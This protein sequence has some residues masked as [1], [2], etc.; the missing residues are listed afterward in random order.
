MD[1]RLSGAPMSCGARRDLALESG[2]HDVIKNRSFQFKFVVAVLQILTFE[3]PLVFQ[4][5]DQQR[6]QFKS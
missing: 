2:I 3:F 5:H 4:R 1:E 6:L